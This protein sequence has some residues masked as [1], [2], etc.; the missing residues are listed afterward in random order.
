MRG[1]RI[2]ATSIL[3]AAALAS[4]VGCESSRFGHVQLFEVQGS[5]G[6]EITDKITVPEGGVIVFEAFPKADGVSPEYVGLER[7]KLRPDDP[8]VA[9]ARRAILR[10]TWVVSG[11]SIGTTRLQVLVDGEVVDGV[12]V[13]IVEEG[14]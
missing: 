6:A 9:E 11:I 2:L 13:E 1:L 5:P 14:Q 12:P 10:D 3:G 8:N 4:A 7:F